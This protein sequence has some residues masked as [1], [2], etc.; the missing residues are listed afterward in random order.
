M[1]DRAPRGVGAA[2]ISG[3][4]SGVGGS[5]SCGSGGADAGIGGPGQVQSPASK[6]TQR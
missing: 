6:H 2:G 5:V 3:A 1:E 4:R